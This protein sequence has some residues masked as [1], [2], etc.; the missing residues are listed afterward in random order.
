[1]KEYIVSVAVMRKPARHFG[2]SFTA[3][4][5]E[6]REDAEMTPTLL[7]VRLH[8]EIPALSGHLL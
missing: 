4:A 2:L 6:L 7:L 5:E 1:M 3:A 8:L